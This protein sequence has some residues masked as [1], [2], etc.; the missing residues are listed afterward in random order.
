MRFT[1]VVIILFCLIIAAPD[2]LAAQSTPL[3]ELLP[4][5]AAANLPAWIVERRVH[6]YI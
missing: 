5:L 3:S 4:N 6:L 1:G 2:H